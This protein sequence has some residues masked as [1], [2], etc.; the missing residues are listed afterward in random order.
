MKNVKYSVYR[1]HLFS[2]ERTQNI[3]GYYYIGAV[4]INGDDTANTPNDAH[5]LLTPFFKVDFSFENAGSFN[6]SN[7]ATAKA[8]YKIVWD[9]C[10]EDSYNDRLNNEEVSLTYARMFATCTDMIDVIADHTMKNNNL[11]D[12]VF[13]Y[14]R[15][16]N[17]NQWNYLGKNQ[18][19]RNIYFSRVKSNN[20][21]APSIQFLVVADNGR[22]DFYPVYFASDLIYSYKP[23]QGLCL[24][25]DVPVWNVDPN[26]FAQVVNYI[27]NIY[28]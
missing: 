23:N 10:H 15:N 25:G 14:T 3:L 8:K 28:R 7:E 6:F 4:Y 5:N 22:I 2:V 24:Q 11:P 16:V 9:T 13:A 17:L 1:G 21:T 18:Y 26:Q 19:G 20:E 27:N 12:R